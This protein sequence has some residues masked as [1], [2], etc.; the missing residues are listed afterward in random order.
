M[1][2]IKPG[3]PAGNGFLKRHKAALEER[4]HYDLSWCTVAKSARQFRHAMQI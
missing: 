4:K 3:S 1:S 2:K